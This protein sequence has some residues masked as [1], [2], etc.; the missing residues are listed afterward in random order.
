MKKIDPDQTIQEQ[1]NDQRKDSKVSS[2]DT[3]E[4]SIHLD[5]NNERI[6]DATGAS[7]DIVIQIF[8]GANDQNEIIVVYTEGLVEQKTIS[9]HILQPISKELYRLDEIQI[10]TIKKKVDFVKRLTST[11]ALTEISNMFELYEQLLSGKTIILVEGYPKAIVASTQGGEERS[12]SEPSSQTVMRGPKDAFIE[13][14]GTNIALIR[15]KIKD[16]NLWLE[17][18]TIGRRTQTKVGIMYI[19][20]VVNTEIV[21][22]V[23]ARLSKIDIDSVLESGYIEEL[24]Q[25]ETFTPFPTLQNTD[26][27]DGVAAALLEGRVAILVDGTPY[28]LLAPALFVQFFQASEDYYQRW[29]IATLVRLLRYLSFLISMLA[30]SLFIAITTFHQELIP[31][32]LVTNLLA[33]REGIPFPAFIEALMMEVTFEILREAGVRMGRAVGT[34]ISIVGTLVIG[35]AAVEAGMVSAAMV[36]VV[37]A[38]AISNFVSPSF[39]MGISSRMLRFIL[40]MLAATLGLYGITLGIVVIV[41]HLCSLKSFGVPYMSSLAP[42]IRNDQKDTLVRIPWWLMLTRPKS[43]RSPNHIRE[44]RR[45]VN[46]NEGD[47][48]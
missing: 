20:G 34:S 1:N 22:E 42:F 5:E 25:D 9:D 27:P 48:T 32:P 13:S 28:V 36:I 6:R 16:V 3:R 10:N 26:R 17:T 24:I 43:F 33:Q 41:L 46:S 15:R 23:R 45:N 30:P 37:S 18:M 7:T 35:Q 29:D 44:Q 2:A 39:N 4:I 8:K 40:M 38:T 14:I 12:I 31:T 11:G 47:T 21:D 19:Q